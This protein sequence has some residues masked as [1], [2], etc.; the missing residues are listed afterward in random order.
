MSTYQP[1]SRLNRLTTPSQLTVHVRGWLEARVDVLAGPR[2]RCATGSLPA[3]W[4]ISSV[5]NDDIATR[6]SSLMSKVVADGTRTVWSRPQFREL[7][8][9]CRQ[10]VSTYV[11]LLPC[12]VP[13][14]G[15]RSFRFFSVRAALGEQRGTER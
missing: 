9:L 14:S 12:S 1:L 5:M 10:V 6:Y 4:R 2:P 13:S 15:Y 8:Y 11:E 7:V 3:T